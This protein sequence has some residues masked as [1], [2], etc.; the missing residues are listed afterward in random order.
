MSQPLDGGKPCPYLQD[1]KNDELFRYALEGKSLPYLTDAHIVKCNSC[2]QQLASLISTNAS[3][4]RSL[5]RCQCP[6]INIL[7]RYAAGLTSLN[8][9]LL[10]LSHLHS[11]P[12]CAQDLQEMR[13]ILED[14]LI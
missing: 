2:R 13:N 1:P 3:L 4:L 14:D 5:Y 10:V 11:C 12:L 9:E 8:E 6:E 7:A